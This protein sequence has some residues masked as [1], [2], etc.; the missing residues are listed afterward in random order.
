MR[1]DLKDFERSVIESVLPKGQPGAYREDD[2]RVL[3]GNF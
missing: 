3:N 1:H 2:R